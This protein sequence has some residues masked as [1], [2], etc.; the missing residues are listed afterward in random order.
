MAEEFHLDRLRRA[1]RRTPFHCS[2][3]L[4][5]PEDD[6]VLYFGKGPEAYRINF[7]EFAAQS[8]DINSPNPSTTSQVEADTT[9]P[10]QD[11]Q[12]VNRR[13][14][15]ELLMKLVEMCDVATFGRNKEDVLDESYRKAVKL[16]TKYFATKFDITSS[17]LLGIIKGDLLA[18]GNAG[19]DVRAE[20]Y[21]LN[22]YAPGGFFKA[23]KDTP[24][25][26]TM[27][28]SAVV[29]LPTPHEGGALILRDKGEEW[30]FDSA[31]LLK[32]GAN[33]PR[34][35]YVAFYS[36]IEHEVAEV[37]S[38]HRVTLTY[39][40]YFESPS[41]NVPRKDVFGPDVYAA[42]LKAEF[43][44]LLRDS[45]FLPDGGYLAFSLSRQYPIKSDTSVAHL[46]ECLKG[47]DAKLREV[48]RQVG[49]KAEFKLYLDVG[50]EIL[51]DVAPELGDLLDDR[52]VIDEL[53][54]YYRNDMWI[55]DEDEEDELI[56]SRRQRQRPRVWVNWVTDKFGWTRYKTEYLTYGNEPSLNCSY[57]YG[58]LIVSVGPFGQRKTEEGETEEEEEEEEEGEGEGEGEE[59][60]EGE[61]EEE[62]DETDDEQPDTKD[63]ERGTN[64]EEI[65]GEMSGEARKE[66]K[67]V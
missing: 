29:V 6:F 11:V 22:V 16:D 61:G 13:S 30:C 17:G 28:G 47:S 27:F 8:R 55:I 7:T 52:D 48:C 14:C 39:N 21:K 36:D 62:T 24:R 53:E 40:L 18:Q 57:G 10:G 12:N 59:E 49:L 23:H 3:T 4:S 63:N 37:I 25:S 1:L 50:E 67:S 46:V 33:D 31:E 2:G 54:E 20:L 60:G 26:K 19:R 58:C 32:N 66:E 45:T 65:A 5:L 34:I 56:D 44:E 35:A 42:K 43:K 64:E 9:Q 51:M 38:G 15:D 41:V